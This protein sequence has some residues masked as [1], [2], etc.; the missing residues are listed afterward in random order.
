MVLKSSWGI[1]IFLDVE[2]LTNPAL[3]DFDIKI[4]DKIYLRISD[5]LKLQQG[6]FESWFI[7]GIQSLSN[8][9]YKKIEEKNAVCFYIKDVNFNYC[10]FQ[11]EGFYCAIR[12]WLAK[13]YEFDIK[14]VNVVFNKKQNRYIFEITHPP[15]A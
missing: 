13:H 3:S 7:Q 15:L 2:E 11:E 1:V 5:S 9:I 10:D 6:L 4:A 8:E 14:P 12:E